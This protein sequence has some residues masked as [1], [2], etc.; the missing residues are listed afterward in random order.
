MATTPE[1]RLQRDVGATEASLSTADATLLL[2]EAVETYPTRSAAASAY[3]RV[4]AIQG[5]L[6]S[7]AKLTSYR[8]NNS[9][10]NQSDIFGH[11]EKLLKRWEDKTAQAA[12]TADGTADV[13]ASAFTV[14]AGTR[15]R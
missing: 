1:Q 3:A 2:A 4:L 9:S 7:S 10:E 11:L 13:P 12:A 5:I 8:Q 15:G 6:A 14:A